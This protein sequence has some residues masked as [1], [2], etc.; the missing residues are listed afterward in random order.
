MP[1]CSLKKVHV[2]GWMD[3]K[4]IKSSLE[5]LQVEIENRIENPIQ[6]FNFFS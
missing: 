1:I 5:V 6:I 3:L 4:W 2:Q